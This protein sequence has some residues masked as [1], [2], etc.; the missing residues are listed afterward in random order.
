MRPATPEGRL[1]DPK[2]LLAPKA[3]AAVDGFTSSGWKPGPGGNASALG[4][5][6]SPAA[7]GAARQA[8]TPQDA[9]RAAAPQ[10]PTPADASRAVPHAGERA[11]GM[12]RMDP[13]STG[14]AGATQVHAPITIHAA[15]QSPQEMG[16]HLQRHI[17]EAWNFRSHDLEP[18]LT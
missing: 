2:A 16:S 3:Q 8:V 10:M 12:V 5:A 6:P 7:A 4:A 18:E 9:A 11:G 17:G 1:L 14:G 13:T 15:N